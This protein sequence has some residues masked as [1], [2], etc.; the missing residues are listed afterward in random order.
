MFE[1]GFDSRVAAMASYRSLVQ[2]FIEL[3]IT[4]TVCLSSLT[5]GRHCIQRMGS[6]TGELSCAGLKKLYK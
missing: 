2:V 1:C 5:W 4:R 6:G 3:N